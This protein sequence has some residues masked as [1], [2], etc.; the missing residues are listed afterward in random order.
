M[1]PNAKP[2]SAAA[3]QR[4]AY[5]GLDCGGCP[6]H[7]GVVPDLA[8]DLRAALRAS[9]YG[10][11]A[12]ALG[13]GPFKAFAKYDDCYEVLGAMVKMRCRR[14]CRDGG[15][16]PVCRIRECCRKRGFDGCW[17]CATFESCPRLEK[18]LAGVHGS[19]C[20]ANLKAIRRGGVKA[21]VAGKPAW[22]R[23]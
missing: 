15:G 6:F 9:R 5:C 2:S 22:Y 14:G 18:Q 13:A 1:A 16:P 23:K 4:V 20:V 10:H 12:A 11:I 3:L 7:A 17:E 8:R 19:A 21:F